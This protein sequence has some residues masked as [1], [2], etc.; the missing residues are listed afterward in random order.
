MT[1]D[2]L[3][4]LIVAAVLLEYRFGKPSPPIE[5]ELRRRA[6]QISQQTGVPVDDIIG[7]AEEIARKAGAETL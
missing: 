5:L 6:E 4:F 3:A 7:W 2:S 1:F